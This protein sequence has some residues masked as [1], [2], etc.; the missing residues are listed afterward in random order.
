MRRLLPRERQRNGA[1][2]RCP[3]KPPREFGAVAGTWEHGLAPK[4]GGIS[5]VQC[6]SIGYLTTAAG[7]V[8]G[9]RTR[10]AHVLRLLSKKRQRSG[11][12]ARYTRKQAREVDAAAG[13]WEHGLLAK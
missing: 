9:T 5:L 4:K 7:V 10:Q 6:P 11:A 8:R 1:Q 3:R 2:A 13:T 12:Q